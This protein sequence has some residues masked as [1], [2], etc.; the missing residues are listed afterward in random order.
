MPINK[1]RQ[2]QSKRIYA[3]AFSIFA[4]LIF[5]YVGLA[6]DVKSFQFSNKIIDKFA[7]TLNLNKNFHVVIIDAGS[8]ASRVIVYNFHN[9]VIN[10]RIVLEDNELFFETKPGLSAFAKKPSKVRSSLE[11]LLTKAKERIPQNSWIMTPLLLRAT[12]GLRLLP[13]DEANGILEE[14]QN[15]LEKSGFHVLPNAVSIMKGSDEV[16]NIFFF[17]NFVIIN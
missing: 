14:C 15:V 1:N 12:A 9:N 13:E 7:Q 6:Y 8:T 4:L 10:D 17:S 16:Q 3:M 5:V 2:R 11:L